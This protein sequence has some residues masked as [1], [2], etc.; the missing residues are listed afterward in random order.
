MCLVVAGYDL[1]GAIQ[2]IRGVIH[3]AILCQPGCRAADNI[4]P[5]LPGKRRQRLP[6]LP[7]VRVG[8]VPYGTR[9]EA[10]L[11]K[12]RQQQHI[13]PRCHGL[14]NQ[15]RQGSKIILRPGEGGIHLQYSGF[16]DYSSLHVFAKYTILADF[17]QPVKL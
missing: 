14:S 15:S 7:A 5:M 4:H 6:C 2:D 16:Q 11:P 9:I 8:V 13:R 1:A 10:H 17:Q 3:Q 12:L